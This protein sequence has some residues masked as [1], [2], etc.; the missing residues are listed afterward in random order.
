MQFPQATITIP[1]Y[2]Q[3]LVSWLKHQSLVRVAF[4]GPKMSEVSLILGP[5]PSVSWVNEDRVEL[6]LVR[7][8]VGTMNGLLKTNVVSPTETIVSSD[9]GAKRRHVFKSS[10]EY[11]S[12][13][14]YA[15]I[16]LFLYVLYIESATHGTDIVLRAEYTHNFGGRR[17]GPR[18]ARKSTKSSR[19]KKHTKRAAPR[20]HTGRKSARKSRR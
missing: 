14:T 18:T 15:A 8:A 13:N 12:T 2:Y 11:A 19:A 10:S 4:P 1:E 7:H 6:P 5:S 9:F 3:D 16:A 20:K 17:S